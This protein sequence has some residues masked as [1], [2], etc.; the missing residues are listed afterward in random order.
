MYYS[1]LRSCVI[2]C[3]CVSAVYTFFVMVVLCLFFFFKQKTADEMRISDWSSDVCSSDLHRHLTMPWSPGMSV[4]EVAAHTGRSRQHVMRAIR[5]GALTATKVRGKHFVTRTEATLWKTRRCPMGNRIISW[6]SVET[7]SKR[8]LFSTSQIRQFIA[9]GRLKSKRGN[10]G[11]AYGIVYVSKI[12]C[13]SDESG[14]G[15]GCV[16]RCRSWWSL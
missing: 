6:I 7:A 1:V 11:A 15:K 10:A 4:A 3:T 8:Y 16:S 12:Q 5:N 14:V 13:R 2:F 9:S